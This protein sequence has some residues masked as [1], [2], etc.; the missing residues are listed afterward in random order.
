MRTEQIIHS[1]IRNLG[2]EPDDVS[3][4]LN[5]WKLERGSAVVD[6]VFHPKSG[7]I[8]GDAWL[9]KIPPEQRSPIYQYM[10]VENDQ[11]E[12]LSFSI[13]ENLVVLS[14]L[15]QD[16]FF[17]V[18]NGTKLFKMLLEKAD[19]YDNILVEQYG[20]TWIEP[21]NADN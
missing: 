3:K 17:S 14:L 10:L 9:C 16:R 18:E 2:D 13:K 8:I 1:I 21:E 15:I 20:A 4:A 12:G 11:L 5:Y 19:Y 7:L 6:L